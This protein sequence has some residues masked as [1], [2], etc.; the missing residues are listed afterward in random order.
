MATD[1]P[2]AADVF[3]D[4]VDNVDDVLAEDI[5]NLQDAVMAVQAAL[6]VN[7]ERAGYSNTETLAANKTL[8]D[9]D[10]PIQFLDPGGA[11]RDVIL[12]AEA[13]TNHGFTI[14]NIA[15]AAETITVK[16]DGGTEIGIV[17]QG[18]TKRMLSNGTAWKM[19]T[20]GS[21]SAAASETAAGI[22]ELA[23][24]AEVSA[25][26]PGL[27]VTPAGLAGSDYGVREIV[28]PLNSSIA[29]TTADEAMFRVPAWMNGWEVVGWGAGCKTGPTGA[30]TVFF[31]KN[32]ATS[33]FSTA[34]SIDAGE[35][36]TLTA[37]TPAVID[38]AHDALAEGDHLYAG[39]TST[40]TGVIAAQ[41]TLTV[42]KPAA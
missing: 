12:P 20:A 26:T 40:G 30:A 18:E 39:V 27:A 31:V 33:M 28:F 7:L 15:D 34:I 24:A 29:L 9:A 2:G 6:L 11:A 25:G 42:R 21:G 5:N 4:K 8:T 10:D 38:T 41:V 37:A 22:V 23:T 1:F 35:T 36:D 16:D 17:A 13:A 14:T 32:G 19:Q 3:A